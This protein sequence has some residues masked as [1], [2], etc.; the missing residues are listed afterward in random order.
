MCWLLFVA[1][2]NGM[3]CLS[4]FVVCGLLVVCVLCLV[5]VVCCLFVGRCS[6]FAVWCYF[7]VDL[8]ALF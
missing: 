7:V 1:C 5:V 3:C 4:L 8:F 6:R 2:C